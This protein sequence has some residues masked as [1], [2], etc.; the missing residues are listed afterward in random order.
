VTDKENDVTD[1][2][3]ECDPVMD[4]THETALNCMRVNRCT[5]SASFAGTAVPS[6]TRADAPDQQR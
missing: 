6:L 4:D 3:S 1:R 5:R 2:I